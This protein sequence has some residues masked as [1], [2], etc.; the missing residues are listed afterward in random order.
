MFKYFCHGSIYNTRICNTVIILL[1]LH[2]FFVHDAFSLTCL[3]QGKKNALAWKLADRVRN[4]TREEVNQMGPEERKK[5]YMC[6][7]K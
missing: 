2:I 3:L 4:L 7:S 1:S 5:P 6:E